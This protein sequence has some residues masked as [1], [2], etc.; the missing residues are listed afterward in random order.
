MVHPKVPYLAAWFVGEKLAKFTEIIPVPVNRFYVKLFGL[1]CPAAGFSLSGWFRVGSLLV[2]STFCSSF[3][4]L[5]FIVR[6]R[7]HNT[8]LWVIFS[9][10]CLS[11]FSFWCCAILGWRFRCMIW[12]LIYRASSLT[13]SFALFRLYFSLQLQTERLYRLL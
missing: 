8:G 1:L 4:S 13:I 5:I 11:L 10:W 12:A 2:I 6:L 3:C 7:L 9:F